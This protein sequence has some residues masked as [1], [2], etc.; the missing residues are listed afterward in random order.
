MIALRAGTTL[1]MFDLNTKQKLKSFKL[2]DDQV[3]GFFWRWINN[4]VLGLV[5]STSVY[6]WSLSPSSSAEPE[7]IFDR[8]ASLASSQ[9]INYRATPDGKWLLLIGIS[10]SQTTP[11]TV[12]GNMQLYSTEKKVSQPLQG[13]AGCFTQVS[14]QGDNNRNI[15]CFVEKKPGF[16]PKMFCMEVGKDKDGREE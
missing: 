13:H 16:G 6:H 1:Q 14:W 4:E 3:N 8:H 11:G 10:P 12:D 5:T 9:I 7:K 15:L 2:E